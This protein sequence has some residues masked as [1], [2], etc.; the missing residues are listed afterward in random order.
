MPQWFYI[1]YIGSIT[2]VAIQEKFNCRGEKC[3]KYI[4]DEAS[5]FGAVVTKV[6]V[7]RQLKTRWIC[8]Y[9]IFADLEGHMQDYFILMGLTKS[10][11][12]LHLENMRGRAVSGIKGCTMP[13]ILP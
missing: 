9:K 7:P 2:I 4:S 1:N 13:A 10:R 5:L 8:D 6:Q 11:Q 3:E 12:W